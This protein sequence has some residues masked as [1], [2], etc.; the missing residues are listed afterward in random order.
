MKFMDQPMLNGIRGILPSLH[1]VLL[2]ILT[3]LHQI[4]ASDELVATSRR[5]NIIIGDRTPE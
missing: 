3:V 5:T 1:A 2:L 4:D